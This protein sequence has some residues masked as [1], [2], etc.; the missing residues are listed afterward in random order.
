MESHRCSA[1]EL[2]PEP[3]P[4]P[5]TGCWSSARCH[6]LTFPS[7]AE[8]LGNQADPRF[9]AEAAGKGRALN[10]RAAQNPRGTVTV[11]DVEMESTAGRDGGHHTY[12]CRWSLWLDGFYKSEVFCCVMAC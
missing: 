4:K 7:Q 6:P 5:P 1:E 3:A 8:E 2:G 11:L 9:P 12:W 10:E